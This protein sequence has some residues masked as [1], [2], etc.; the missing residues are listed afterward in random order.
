MDGWGGWGGQYCGRVSGYHPEMGEKSDANGLGHNCFAL[1]AASARPEQIQMEL[2]RCVVEDG[3][4]PGIIIST[5]SRL[6]SVL[7]NVPFPSALGIIH[8]GGAHQ[9][10]PRGRAGVS[11]G[12]CNM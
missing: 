5:A 1:P 10:N 2:A 7:R 12:E 3:V 11:T 4:A 6:T 9:S 8:N